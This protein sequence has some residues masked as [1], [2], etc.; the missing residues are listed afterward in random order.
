MACFR[1][2][3]RRVSRPS[4]PTCKGVGVGNAASP[5]VAWGG[6][7]RRKAAPTPLRLAGGLAFTWF[8]LI[9]FHLDLDLCHV[10]C[11]LR[12]VEKASLGEKIRSKSSFPHAP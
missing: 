7:A 8:L 4:R 1:K 12:V 10:R 6:G 11:H 2:W 5:A 9:S 3:W